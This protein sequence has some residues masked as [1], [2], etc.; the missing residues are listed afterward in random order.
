MYNDILEMQQPDSVELVHF[1]DDIRM[2]VSVQNESILMKNTITTLQN[3]ANWLEGRG[4]LLAPEKIGAVFQ[5][6]NDSWYR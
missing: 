6:Q 1:A 4:L 5:E 2:V 3:V